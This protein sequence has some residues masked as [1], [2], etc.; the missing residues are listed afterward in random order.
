MANAS[1]RVPSISVGSTTASGLANAKRKMDEG[2]ANFQ[3]EIDQAAR[4]TG[5][6]K[7]II[8]PFICLETGGTMKNVRN[9]TTSATGLMQLM[10]N[11]AGFILCLMKKPIKANPELYAKIEALIGGKRLR[12]YTVPGMDDST[13]K[14]K[15]GGFSRED[16]DNP[17]MNVLFGSLCLQ[18]LIARNLNASG[19]I[20]ME[21]VIVKYNQGLTTTIPVYEPAKVLAYAKARFGAEPANYIVKMTGVNG[22]LSAYA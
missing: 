17:E 19:S 10:P 13:A 2:Y 4:F 18:Y 8:L 15:Y 5:V 9:K 21:R 7:E 6:P 1:L 12:G 3:R 11:T 20:Q 22:Y 14:R 16:L